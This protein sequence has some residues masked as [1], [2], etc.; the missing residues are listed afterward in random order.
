MAY[1]ESRFRRL[2]DNPILREM[3]AETTLAARQLVQP[4]FVKEGLAGRQPIES[5]PGQ[6]QLGLEE[7][8]KEAAS[9]RKAG[10]P[11]VLLFGIPEEKD[12]VGSS[13][14]RADGIIPQ[15]IRAI[16]AETTDLAVIIDVCLCEYTDHGHCGVLILSG[17]YPAD[18]LW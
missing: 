14:T 9:A 18:C 4:L 5:M 16:K 11:A 15:A 17:R 13:A 2:R 12:A 6:A 8:A 3:V 10:V 7:L 1:P